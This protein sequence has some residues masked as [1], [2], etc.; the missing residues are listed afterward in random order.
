[1]D[2]AMTILFGGFHAD[3]Y[4]YYHIAFPLENGWKERTDL[5]NTYPLLVHL[6]LFGGMYEKGVQNAFR[7]YF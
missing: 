6:V 3:L 2:I 4:K 5:C 7:R 1:M